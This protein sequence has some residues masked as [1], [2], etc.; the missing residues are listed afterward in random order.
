MQLVLTTVRSRLADLQQRYTQAY[1]DRD[2]DL[3]AMPDEIRSMEN[4]LAQTLS[5]ARATVRDEARQA[6]ETAEVS[7]TTLERELS[8]HQARVQLFTDRFK[9]FK[10]LEEDLARLEALLA[11]SKERLAQ[12]QVSNLQKYP[13]I[14]VV[15]WARLPLRPIYPDYERDLMIALV[16]A[17][18]LALFVTWLVEYLSERPRPGQAPPYLGVRI[19]PADQAQMLQPPRAGDRL[20]YAG[21]EPIEA[22]PAELPIL[23]RELAR[24]ETASLLAAADAQAAGYAALLLSGIS[25]YELPLLHAACF[26]RAGG[27][28]E[29]PG[30][31]RR[32][33]PLVATAWQRIGGI[34]DEMDHARM[35]LPL[36][37]LDQRLASAAQ[38]AGLADPGSI[39]GRALWHTYLVY[40]IR[41][42][43]DNSALAGRVGSVP[44][45]VLRALSHLAPPGGNRPLS[46]IDFTYPAL[47][48]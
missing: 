5:L 23:P 35:A 17:L 15:E 45:D 47:S 34:I 18:A 3:K 27:R 6:T 10:A 40:L 9:E 7:V 22:P 24:A 20:A 37:E 12:I 41:Q 11:D 13:P 36:A 32:S 16:G 26:D 4:A 19:Y 33:L 46:G 30:A 31:S 39:N 1:I 42:G 25:P 43:I 29:V 14:Q 38:V 44:T 28:I 8:E 2:P 48:A 21:G